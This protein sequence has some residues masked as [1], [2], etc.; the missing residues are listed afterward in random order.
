MICPNFLKN[1]LMMM[2]DEPLPGEQKVVVNFKDSLMAKRLM[3]TKQKILH[4]EL[5][6][7]DNG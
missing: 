5:E 3:G 2:I 7:L 4:G 1:P 6:V